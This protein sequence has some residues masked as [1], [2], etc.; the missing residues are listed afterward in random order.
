[1][2][3]IT[4]RPG[5][6]LHVWRDGAEVAAVPLSPSAALS[7]ASDLLAAI[8]AQARASEGQQTDLGLALNGNTRPDCHLP[9]VQELDSGSF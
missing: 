9:R 5:P 6:V 4:V 1:M 7:I 8:V 2:I 3:L